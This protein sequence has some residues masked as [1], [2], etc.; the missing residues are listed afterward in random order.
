MRLEIDTPSWTYRQ[1]CRVHGST[2]NGSDPH[3]RN[4]LGWLVSANGARTLCWW[5][6]CGVR[7]PGI[8]SK[9]IT[10][11]QQACVEVRQDNRNECCKDENWDRFLTKRIKRNGTMSYRV[12]CLAC[13]TLGRHATKSEVDQFPHVTEWDRTAGICRRCRRPGVDLHHWAPRSKFA[14]ADLWGT[15]PLCPVCHRKW[16]SVMGK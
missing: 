5:C 9:T 10:P 11:A 1:W 4:E 12:S 15:V 8:P 7:G 3:V 14:D 13:G 16:H 2:D 6:A